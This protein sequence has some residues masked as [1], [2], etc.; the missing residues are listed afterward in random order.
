MLS[1]AISRVCD[2]ISLTVLVCVLGYG[3]YS[4]SNRVLRAR[5]AGRTAAQ[6]IAQRN[7]RT[8][9]YFPQL[10]INVS[11]TDR[12]SMN[13]GQLKLVRGCMN[14]VLLLLKKTACPCLAVA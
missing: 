14:C 2:V 5:I 12:I 3:S 1:F 7:V 13:R 4:M 8:R 6:R 9:R 10:I 11:L